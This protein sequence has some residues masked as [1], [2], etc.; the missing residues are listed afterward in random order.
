M[1]VTISGVYNGTEFVGSTI[2]FSKQ[3]YISIYIIVE[4]MAVATLATYNDF[5][6]IVCH[7]L[8]GS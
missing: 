5:V 4:E 6:M 1:K 2:I 3:N 7:F 8:F